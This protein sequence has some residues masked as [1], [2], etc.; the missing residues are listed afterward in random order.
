MRRQADWVVQDETWQSRDNALLGGSQPL[1]TVNTYIDL[2]LTV[3]DYEPYGTLVPMERYR[4]KE[5]AS[6]TAIAVRGHIHWQLQPRIGVAY[7]TDLFSRTWRLMWQM[8]IRTWPSNPLTHYEAAFASNYGLDQPHTANES[9]VWHKERI[10]INIAS[11]DWTGTP[12]VRTPHFGTVPVVARFRRRLE[13]LENL[14]LT[15]GWVLMAD[16]A[17]GHYEVTP[18]NLPQLAYKPMLRTLV[19]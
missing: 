18:A 8:R 11:D 13:G 14:W 17:L 4:E 7:T 6:R 15:V 1:L 9:F 3:S 19:L 5:S 10:L 12:A 2:P 16:A